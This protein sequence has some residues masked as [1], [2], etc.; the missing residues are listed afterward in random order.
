MQKA[1]DRPDHTQVCL[2]LD[3]YGLLLT[4]RTRDVLELY[5]QE[6]MSL[7]EIA[8]ELKISRQGVHDKIRQGVKALTDYE[9]KLRLS[10]RF[11]LQKNL[12]SDAIVCLDN[13]DY[14]GA[15]QIINKLADIL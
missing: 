14:S 11:L 8:D 10:E 12:A 15:R 9:D 2:W 3:F 5:F 1:V 4:D 7:S 13:E 6:D